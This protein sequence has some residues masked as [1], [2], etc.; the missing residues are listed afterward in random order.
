[1]KKI[2]IG[3]F[4]IVVVVAAALFW[5]FE[6]KRET[7]TNNIASST[8]IFDQS[9]S[10]GTIK[11]AY[12]SSEFGLAVNQAQV[13]VH[14]YIPPCDE[15][16]GYCIY[17]NGTQYQG[18][19]FES[20]GIRVQ[21]RTDLAN[22]NACLNTPKSGYSENIK[23]DTTKSGNGYSSSVFSNIGDAGAGHYAV[24]SLYRL[25]VKSNSTCYEFETRIGQ[26]QFLNYPPG[27]IKEFTSDDMKNVQSDL[28]DI[29]KQVS[30]SSGEKNVI[31]TFTDYRD[32]TYLIEGQPVTLTNGQAES[33]IVPGSI[34]KTIT[35]YFGNIAEGDLNADN[36]PDVAF[37]LTQNSG[38]SGTFYYA[39]AALKTVNGYQG[40]NAI[41]LGDR[42]SPQTTEIK[43]GE[44]I[45]NYADRKPSDPMTAEPSVGVSK[46]LKIQKGSLV[47]VKPTN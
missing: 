17:Y 3:I 25:F 30:L 5:K 13:L 46:Y 10:D 7:Q 43:N 16:F 11:I 21:K 36:I 12:P 27:A 14:S 8:L 20:A 19:N 32:A 42:I 29:I 35:Q 38:G 23:P 37:L 6:A 44:I 26:T 18:T 31:L 33:I 47:E 2:L 1:M 34:E 41:F 4:V 9:I 22:E 40:T 45:V 24:G 28:A 39:V 15:G